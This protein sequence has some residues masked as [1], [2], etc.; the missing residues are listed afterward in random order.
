MR[1]ILRPALSASICQRSSNFNT[2]GASGLS[3]FIG[4]R[5]MPGTVAATSQLFALISITATNVLDWS[6]G[7]TER[8]KSFANTTGQPPSAD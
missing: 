8:L 6:K 5:S 1:D 4:W 2:V 3:F 7:V